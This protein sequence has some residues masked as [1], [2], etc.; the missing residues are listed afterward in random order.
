MCGES[1]LTIRRLASVAEF[2]QHD[3]LGASS[4]RTGFANASVGPGIRFWK[5]RIVLRPRKKTVAE[6]VRVQ[7]LLRI[8]TNPAT[9]AWC[10]F[11][12]HRFPN[13]VFS[14]LL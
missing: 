7:K 1:E 3:E 9:Y 4:H 8:L 14:L 11:M 13:L 2:S 10:R 6:L 5:Y 12:A